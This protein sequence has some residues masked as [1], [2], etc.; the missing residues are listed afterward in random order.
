[1]GDF[2]DLL[3]RARSY[4]LEQISALTKGEMQSRDGMGEK[5]NTWCEIESEAQ[6]L[7]IFKKN[8]EGHQ[9]KLRYEGL[10][11]EILPAVVRQSDIRIRQEILHDVINE[12]GENAKSDTESAAFAL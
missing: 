7:D 3:K 6:Y 2:E 11:G 8:T 1:M 10:M 12:V 5:L 9:D 4:T